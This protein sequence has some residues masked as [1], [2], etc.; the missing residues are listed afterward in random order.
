MFRNPMK[1]YKR[2]KFLQHELDMAL[3]GAYAE[4]AARDVK[5]VTGPQWVPDEDGEFLHAEM[6]VGAFDSAI[7]AMRQGQPDMPSF[8]MD[9]APIVPP[10]GAGLGMAGRG[11]TLQMDYFASQSFIGWEA[12]AIMSQNWFINAGCRILAEDG[13]KNGYEITTNDGD[14]LSPEVIADFKVIDKAMNLKAA[15]INF[16]AKSKLFGTCMVIFQV[17]SDDPKYYQK[18]F[19][20]DS[21]TPGSYLGMSQVD[22]TWVLPIPSRKSM[23]EFSDQRF[24]RPTWYQVGG[25]IYHYSHL[26]VINYV[27]PPTVMAPA[28]LYGGIPLSQM[29]MS[30]LYNAEAC[31]NEGPKLLA[32]KRTTFLKT[33]LKNAFANNGVF[34]RTWESFSALRNN[35]S[36][37]PIGEE[38]SVDMN[39]TSL[40]DVTEV[41]ENN[42]ILA[43]A[44]MRVTPSSMVKFSGKKGGIGNESDKDERQDANEVAK[45]QD[46]MS[47]L[48]ERHHDYAMKSI[49]EPKHGVQPNI[50]HVWNPIDTPTAKEL[51]ETDKLKAETRSIYHDVGA[52]SSEEIAKAIAIENPLAITDTNKK[53][54]EDLNKD[55]IR[56]IYAS[57]D[58]D[59]EGEIN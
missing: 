33:S 3:A 54:I 7:I 58:P 21:V 57:M 50:E 26:A 49:I 14:G 10:G 37:Q 44:I 46:K 35:F 56:N 34:Q 32:T 15:M 41:I 12:C 45:A 24:N 23:S 30:R 16:D 17:K 2:H 55:E 39:D 22:A 9:A 27:E 13:V 52:L 38:D 25:E 47:V 59:F 11:G 5:G 6:A 28:Y 36:V 48:L 1:A 31:A 43:C 4:D 53:V 42:F 29:V 8:A 40:T 20:M 19:N 51:A 18:P